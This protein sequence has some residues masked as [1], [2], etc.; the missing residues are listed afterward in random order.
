MLDVH[1]LRLV[2]RK[3]SD[4]LDG[5]LPGELLYK[6]KVSGK[7]QLVQLTKLFLV[8]E[9][10]VLVATSKV[11]SA[12]AGGFGNDCAV[13]EAAALEGTLADAVMRLN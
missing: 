5:T 8:Q 10:L 12:F 4:Q 1:L 7:Q 11:Q 2:A 6:N 3:C 13:V 9:I